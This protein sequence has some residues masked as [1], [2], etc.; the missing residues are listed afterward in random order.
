MDPS[1]E[2]GRTAPAETLARELVTASLAYLEGAMVNPA[3][4]PGLVPLLLKNHSVTAQLIVRVSAHR[5]WLKPYEVKS[6]IVQHPKTPRAVAMNLVQFLW[7]RDLAQVADETVL[8]PP[9]RRAA[10]R[11]LSV[12]I[13]ELALGE[14]IALARIASRGVI[15]VLRRQEHPMVIRAL[16]QNPRLVEEDALA[17]AGARGTPAGVLQTLAEDARFS[18]RPAV[19]KALVQNHGTPAATALRILQGLGTET[20]KELARAPHVP[21]LVKVAV[22]RMMD[23]REHP[24]GGSSPGPGI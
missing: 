12:R 9:L 5:G 10:E 23:A 1:F 11:I 16:L 7:W 21:T 2:A 14:R 3:M 18:P 19:Q 6:A 22:Q 20:L 15:H 4:Q 24:E 8:A 13:Q 17:I